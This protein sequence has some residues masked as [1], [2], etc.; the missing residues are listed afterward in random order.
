MP[1][2]F[3]TTLD[4]AKAEGATADTNGAISMEQFDTRGLPMFGGCEVCGASITA[5]NAYPSKSGFLRC[6]DC[7]DDHGYQTVEEFRQDYARSRL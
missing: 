1:N 2:P 7:I 4:I 6:N 5:Y 3:I